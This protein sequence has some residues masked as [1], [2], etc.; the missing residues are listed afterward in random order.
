MFGTHCTIAVVMRIL[1]QLEFRP[2][3]P[4][5]PLSRAITTGALSCIPQ[6]GHFWCS[7]LS[8]TGKNHGDECS[9]PHDSKHV[10][11]CLVNVHRLLS[12]VKRPRRI[13]MPATVSNGV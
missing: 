3:S 7:E 12:L 11:L 9:R 2:G 4:L 5:C 8:P 1:R 13:P 10:E 6:F